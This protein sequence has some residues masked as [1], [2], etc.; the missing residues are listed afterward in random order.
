M[1]LSQIPTVELHAEL[2][3]RANDNKTQQALHTLHLQIAADVAPACRVE[4]DHL[5]SR[6][7]RSHL[8]YPRY[9]LM[10]IE[11]TL[12]W[13]LQE[14]AD[15]FDYDHTAIMYGLQRHAV[16]CRTDAAYY[17]ATHKL[18]TK[19]ATPSCAR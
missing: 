9:M 4:L 7:R 16:R 14:I 18:I 10:K 15:L 13:N 17:E 19:Y 5:L 11:R 1:N 6:S 8:T 2:F 3:R 12:G